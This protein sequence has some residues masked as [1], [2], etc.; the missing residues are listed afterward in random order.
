M[1]HGIRRH[2]RGFFRDAEGKPVGAV[3]NMG[4]SLIWEMPVL[5][6]WDGFCTRP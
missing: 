2:R 3:I 5:I 6:H 1:I 4:F